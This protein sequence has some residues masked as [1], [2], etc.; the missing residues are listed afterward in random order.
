MAISKT[1][2][3]EDVWGKFR[4]K[5]WKITLDTS[6]PTGGYGASLGFAPQPLGVGSFIGV[7]IIGLNAAGSGVV[8]LAFDYTNNKLMAFRGATFTPAGSITFTD[9]S[10][11]VSYSPG[12]GDIKGATN[13]AGT[14]GNADQNAGATNGAL[15]LAATTF[16]VLAGTMTPTTQPDVPRNIVIQIENDSGGALDLFEGTTTFAI[17]GTDK[18]GDAQTE[19]VTLVSTGG[20]KSVANTKF[21]YVQGVKPFRTVTSIAI[22]N[23]PAGGLKGSLGVGTRIGLPTALDTAAVADV[24]SI[25]VN[26]ARVAPTATVTNA[27]GVDTTNNAINSGTISDGADVGV[28]YKE[29]FDG[30]AATFTGTAQGQVAQAEVSN[31]VN[32]SAVSAR[33]MV[34]G[35]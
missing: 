19:N 10:R 29:D 33:I 18:N 25:T 7:Y 34:I 6:Y 15:L 3:D 8:Q 35:R 17:T 20:N 26:G 27:G 12:G 16:T 31:A 11:L 23:A 2:I 28:L 14:E 22:T 4:I 13:L 32:L 5:L 21:R 30:S 9:G 24:T 1:F